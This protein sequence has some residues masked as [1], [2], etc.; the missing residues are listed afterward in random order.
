MKI[1]LSEKLKCFKPFLF[2]ELYRKEKAERAKGKNII[3]L[4][5]GDP[6][7]P[8]DKAIVACA[9]AETRKAANH[10][11][12]NTR[13]ND[14]LRRA[15]AEWHKRRHGLV[16]DHE[17]EI[18]ILIGSKEGI[19]HLPLVVMNRGDYCLI[20]DPTY[21]TY[22]TGVLLAEGRIHDVPL[23]EKNDF[24]PDLGKIP[25]KIA[26]RAKLFFLNY[27]NNPTG[28]GV[29]LDFFKELVKWA[30]KNEIIIAQDAA[31]CEIYFDK[32]SPSIFEVQGARDVAV[33]FYSASK[34]Y[35][36]A[37]WRTGWVA[38][39]GKLVCALNQLKENI[40]SGQ[41][42]AVQNAVAYAL[43]N[44]GSIVPRIRERFKARAEAFSRGLRECGWQLADPKGSCFIWARP[45][46][47]ISSIDAVCLML[48]RVALLAAPGSGFGKYGEGYVRFSLTEPEAALADAIKRIKSLNW[49]E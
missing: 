47:K 43:R 27:P 5:V 34:T 4:A 37:G 21:P 41:F 15:A 42:N 30:R 39:N 31:Y 14:N 48:E 20:P 40:D 1:E 45:P 8:T 11:Y 33:E 6:D 13:G 29:T 7:I 28:A 9:V 3:S 35:C 10:R 23:E 26:D 32:P 17:K 19:A 46:A 44:H 36:M 2:E 38:G 25:Q 12:S 22:R 24:L 49:A 16:F 18:S